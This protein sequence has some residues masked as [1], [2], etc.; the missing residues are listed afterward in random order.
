MENRLEALEQIVAMLLKERYTGEL[1]D[2]E[3]DKIHRFFTDNYIEP[4]LLEDEY[5][6]KD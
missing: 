6:A 1:S 5:N 3:E 2:T 4:H